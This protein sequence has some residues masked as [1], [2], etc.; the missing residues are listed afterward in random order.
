MEQREG[1]HAVKL[2]VGP[3]YLHIKHSRGAAVTSV[4]A[5]I[6]EGTS[7]RT[8]M[9]GQHQATQPPNPPPIS[10]TATHKHP[11]LSTG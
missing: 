7:E 11:Q 6:A 5:V 1:T 8:V 9:Q 4:V 3:R 10:T 2:L